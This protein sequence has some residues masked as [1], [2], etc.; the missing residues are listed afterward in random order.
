MKIVKLLGGLGNQMFQYAFFLAL[1]EKFKNVRLDISGFQTYELHNGL[2]LTSIFNLPLPVA[3]SFQIRLYDPAYRGWFIRKLRRLVGLK[4]VYYQEPVL[5]EF[6]AAVLNDPKKRLYWG[7]WQNENYFIHISD[8]IRE[9]FRFI[10][11]LTGK[12][13]DLSLQIGHK[14]SVSIHVR[15]G[16]YINHGLLG[17]ICDLSYY[18]KAIQHIRSMVPNAHFIVFSND[19]D[20]CKNNLNLSEADFVSW[21]TGYNSYID[22]QLMSL[23]KHNI[24]A[25]SSFSWWGAWLNQHTDKIVIA[26]EKWTN[27]PAHQNCKVYSENWLKI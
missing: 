10:K 23:C 12:N 22:M 27:D 4:H 24:I 13:L 26:S 7:Y 16:D 18:E 2:E 21:N 25:N 17:G 14:E 5:F 20:W 11:P 3:S 19:I 8:K 6:D 1:S 15:R 9:A